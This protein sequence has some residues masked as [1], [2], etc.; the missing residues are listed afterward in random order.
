MQIAKETFERRCLELA[1]LFGTDVNCYEKLPAQMAEFFEI[2]GYK[3]VCS[4]LII[5]ELAKP[6]S[7]RAIARQYGMSRRQI[8]RIKN[9]SGTRPV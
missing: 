3:R 4:L 6:R 2:V 5:Q 1:R 9:N 7:Q 8:E